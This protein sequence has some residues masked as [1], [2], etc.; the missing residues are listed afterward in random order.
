M[1][2]Y[3]RHQS[4]ISRNADENEDS[5]HWLNQ[6]EKK[7][8][9]EAVQPRAVD[10]S[11][12]NQINSIMGNKKSKYPSVQA[13]VDDMQQRSGL[14]AY[15]EKIKMSGE[16]SVNKKVASEEKSNP[17]N[18]EL[19]TKFPTIRKTFEN[20]IRE[21]KGNLPISAIIDHVRS[22]HQRDVSNAKLWDDDNLIRMVSGLNLIAKKD[23]PE[24]Y[25]NHDTLGT[26]DK[27]NS[28]EI[29]ISNTDAFSGLNPVKF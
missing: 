2:K 21:T 5:D 7:L 20:Y 3:T 29:D 17:N 23:N 15:L 13:A 25:Y 26:R 16:E 10:D 27:S 8:Q 18:P 24:N 6:F 22:I 12:F 11:L 1:S 14:T 19:F 4:V 9:K 28:S